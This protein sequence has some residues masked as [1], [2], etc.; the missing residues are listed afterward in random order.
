M[1][2]ILVSACLLGEQVRYDGSHK[3]S[4]HPIL[5]QWVAENRVISICPE[6]SGGM[7]VPRLPAEI[8]SGEG[9]EKVLQRQT[10]VVN[11]SGADVSHPFIVGAQN[12]LRIARLHEIHIAVL[13]EGSP[14]CGSHQVYD[15]SFKGHLVAGQGVTAT[16]LRISGIFVFSE[17][18][19][20]DAHNMLLDLEADS[21]ASPISHKP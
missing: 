10:S 12:A 1:Q 8:A 18:E 11:S 5:Q 17:M 20:N 16:L 15:G 7:P 2:R 9:G 21:I 4:R 3:Q 6:L 14:S 13:K 19:F